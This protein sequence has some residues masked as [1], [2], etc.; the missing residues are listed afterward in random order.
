MLYS[1]TF[2]A[3]IPFS[4]ERFKHFWPIQMIQFYLFEF[5]TIICVFTVLLLWIP[6]ASMTYRIFIISNM[7]K[8]TGTLATTVKKSTVVIL[9]L[10]ENEVSFKFP[11]TKFNF[12]ILFFLYFFILTSWPNDKFNRDK[13]CRLSD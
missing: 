11:Y 4:F 8:W 13:I 12:S 9:T 2:R 3:Y 1:W 10:V 6:P 7:M 5:H